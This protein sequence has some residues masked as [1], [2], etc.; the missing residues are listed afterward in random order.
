M[1]NEKPTENAMHF[2]YL[3]SYIR[4]GLRYRYIQ[5]DY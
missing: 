2:S 4:Q 3:L 1:E 5:P